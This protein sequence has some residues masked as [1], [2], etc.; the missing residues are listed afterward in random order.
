[1]ALFS[2]HLN[3]SV[4]RSEIEMVDE[5][6]LLVHHVLVQSGPTFF[7]HLVQ[8]KALQFQLPN[9]LKWRYEQY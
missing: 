2:I 1:M 9:Q 4:N 5:D 8:F 7:C 3:V 6:S